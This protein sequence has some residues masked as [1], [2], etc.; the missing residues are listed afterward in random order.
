MTYSLNPIA[1]IFG[2][3]MFK[4]FL[5]VSKQTNQWHLDLILRSFNEC[6]IILPGSVRKMTTDANQQNSY[7]SESS[8]TDC[9]LSPY[10]V[11]ASTQPTVY[12][13]EFHHVVQGRIKRK[14]G[15]AFG[16][17]NFGVNHTTLSPGSSSALQHHH[18][19]QDEFIFILKGE[20]V[21]LFGAKE[22]K[23]T[24]GECMGFPAGQGIGH[25]IINRS[26][27]DVEYLE[28]GDRT[29]N[30]KVQYTHADLE[31]NLDANGQWVFT[32]KDGTPY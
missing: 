10:D 24:A 13:I 20:A 6:K 19:N 3:R 1:H 22:I 27:S 31:A 12:P 32:H 23:I 25:A 11:P 18:A 21:L 7:I 17:Q 28:I 29:P 9:P 5:A 26:D 30:D 2:R 15:N 4:C 14:L 16:L 8:S